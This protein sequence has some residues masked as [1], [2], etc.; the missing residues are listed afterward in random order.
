MLFM[1]EVWSMNRKFKFENIAA[2][3]EFVV[4]SGLAISFHWF[5]DYKEAAFTIFGVGILLS[6]ATYLLREELSKVRSVLVKQ[7]TQSHEITSA[8]ALITDPE[9]EAKA[10][11][12]LNSAK[13]TFGILQQGY[14]PLSETEFY[15]ETA[16]A[17]DLVK[18]EIKAVDP[19]ATSWDT[20]SAILNLYQGNLRALE[21]EVK[22]MRIFV[23]TRDEF[24]GPEVQKILTLQ[25]RDGIDVRVAYRDEL[26]AAGDHTWDSPQSYNFAVYDDNLVTDVFAMPGPYFGR[27]T[28]Q[29]AEVNKYLRILEIIEHNAY[30]LSLEDEKLVVSHSAAV[31][32]YHWSQDPIKEKIHV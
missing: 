10:T 26:P 13:K 22:I 25:L 15:L 27:K 29:T 6:L 11:E 32:P 24:P 7:Y 20:R 4:G 30:R 2:L 23:V 16:R 12:I 5:L 3:I 21:R 1:K 18:V 28:S 8:L 17:T 31:T 14:V 9:C 19:F